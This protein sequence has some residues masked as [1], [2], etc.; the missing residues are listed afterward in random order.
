MP[1]VPLGDAVDEVSCQVDVHVSGDRK[2]WLAIGI[3]TVVGAVWRVSML[4]SKWSQPLLFNDSLYYSFQA[5]ANAHGQWFRLVFTGGPGAEHPPLASLLMT[6]ASLLPHYVFWQ[7]ATNTLLGIAIIPL[8]GLLGLRVGGRRVAIVAACIAALYPNL[9]MNDSLVMSESSSALLVVLI[10]LCAWRLQEQFDL[11]SAA[12]T[13]AVIGLAALS[14]SELVL[15]APLL[16]FV[17]VRSH[18]IREWAR[19]AVLVLA[20]TGLVLLPWVAYNLSRFDAPVLLSTN[21]GITLLG[22][23]CDQTYSGAQMGGWLTSCLRD[24]VP[25]VGEDPSE[26]SKRERSA[27]LQYMRDHLSRVPVVVAARF[28]R[29][30]NLYGLHDLVRMDVGDERPRWASWGGILSWWLLTPLAMFGWWKGRRRS[31]WILAVPVINAMVT[32]ALFYGAHRLRSPME[33]VVVVCAAMGMISCVDAVRS[34]A[35][36]SGTPVPPEAVPRLPG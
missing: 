35:A 3:A 22:S 12:L 9:W 2:L 19:R 25:R 15:L 32:T 8:I 36:A 28:L 24:I 31:G 10:L 11:R 34:R 18:P 17:G 1:E 26:L 13:G 20:T 27:A 23:N 6:P 33:P 14:R 5:R 7:R 30:G 29:A 16:A 21:D 4:V